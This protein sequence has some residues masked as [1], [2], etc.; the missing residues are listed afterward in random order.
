MELRRLL[1]EPA[2]G[3]SHLPPRRAK[4]PMREGR[5]AAGCNCCLWGLGLASAAVLL[6]LLRRPVNTVGQDAGGES[7]STRQ[8]QI[9]PL[10]PPPPSLPPPAP[11]RPSKLI[12]VAAASKRT[13]ASHALVT[14][15]NEPYVGFTA[16]WVKSARREWPRADVFVVAVE[17]ANESWRCLEGFG[18]TVLQSRWRVQPLSEYLSSC[19]CNEG[20]GDP[21]FRPCGATDNANG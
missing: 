4:R 18:A 10:P 13:R 16:T 15:S 1:E 19:T 21:F 7:A 9:T 2:I 11:P 14:I 12:S 17:M 6:L 20:V 5:D 3:R 8:E